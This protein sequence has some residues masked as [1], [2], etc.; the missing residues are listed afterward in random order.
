MNR[1]PDDVSEMAVA[2]KTPLYK[3]LSLAPRQSPEW[4]KRVE[5]LLSGVAFLPSPNDFNDP[6]DCLPVPVTPDT[7]EEM[8][9]LGENFIERMVAA[10]DEDTP[11]RVRAFMGAALKHL[12]PEQ[13]RELVRS[14]LVDSMKQLGIFCMA[15][16]HTNVLM[17]S[18]YANNHRGIALRFETRRQAVGGLQPW[19]KVNYQKQRPELR[20]FFHKETSVIDLV[21]ALCTKAEF[22]A[23][24]Q[25]WRIIGTSHAHKRLRFDANVITGLILGAKTSAEDEAWLRKNIEGRNIELLRAVPSHKTFDLEI[26]PA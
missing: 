23:Y 12:T 17:W 19:F 21:I 14:S 2:P 24:E 10:V 15:E 26:V 13:V 22:W 4:Q 5:E 25:E 16:N 8:A 11:E 3:Y 20:R 1:A 6:F 7:P 9:L 18:H